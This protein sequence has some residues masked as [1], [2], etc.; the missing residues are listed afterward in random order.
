[1]IFQYIKPA[2]IFIMCLIFVSACN[3]MQGV[4]DGWQASPDVVSQQVEERPENLWVEGDVPSYELPG[5][6]ETSNGGT[7]STA[8]EWEP[9]R[10]EILEQFRSSMYGRSPGA[11][12]YLSFELIEENSSAMD[13][14]AT[15]KRIIAHSI[16]GGRT[17]QF[18]FSL[19]LPNAA[20]GPVPV[21]TLINNRDR[22]NIDPTRE[23]KS[24]FWP[25]EQVIER[26]YGIAA[27]QNSD[28]APDNAEDYRNGVIQLFEGEEAYGERAPDAWE[29]LAAWGWGASRVMDYLETDPGVDASKVALVGHSRGG[30]ASLWAGAEDERFAVV[31][32]NDSGSGGAALS[33][34]QFGETVE[35]V[36][37]FAH[38][39]AGNFDEYNNNEE[40]LPFDQHMLVALIA[41][42]AVYIASADRDLWADPKGEFLSLAH[43][44]PVYSLWGHTPIAPEELP[45]LN[46][47]LV[48]GPRGY[49]VREGGHNLTTV[50]WHFYM[51]FTDTIFVE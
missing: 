8:E 37:R 15:L 45:E 1:M 42:R 20:N 30:K 31:I 29:A 48:A 34:R 41:P 23:N 47:P 18:E 2:L 4:S 26:G 11:P 3:S 13:G 40:A 44:S 46:S 24:D 27:F 36:N 7:V 10:A 21:Y 43:A 38:W 49:H 14:A 6:L 22:S 39:F 5:L 19:F 16:H 51:D 50:D 17:H 35:D 25:A 9:R 33:R 32:A 12:V 28:L